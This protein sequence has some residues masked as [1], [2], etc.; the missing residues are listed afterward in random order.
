M[1]PAFLTPPPLP[2]RSTRAR[3]VSP[4]RPVM[5][6]GRSPWPFSRFVQTLLFYSP[7]GRFLHGPPTDPAERVRSARV[8]ATPGDSVVLV[9]GAN[10]GT[11]RR[12]V[13]D[14]LRKKGIVVRALVRT[15]AKLVE[16][17]A[18]VGVD[19]EQERKS[20]KL[21][22]VVS[23]LFNI[24]PEFFDNVVAVASCTGVNVGPADDP[25]RSKYFQ[26]VKFYPPSILDDTPENVEFVG[27]GNLVEA[28]KKYFKEG[29]G[30]IPVLTFSDD[31]IVRKQW[32]ALDD[33]VM[34]GVSKGSVRTQN[35][36]LVFSGFVSTDNSGG[37]SSARTTDFAQPLDVSQYDGFRLRVKGDGKSYKFIVR[38]EDKWDGIAHCFT[39]PT[40]SG[41]WMDVDIPFDQF[42][43]V[44]RA[45]TL[46]DGKPLDPKK[47]YAFQV[48]LSK[49][50]YD[51]ELN[52]NF[53]A[54]PF[55]LQIESVSAYKQSGDGV[56]RP[57]I[58]HIS[59]AAVTRVLRKSEFTP[60]QLPPAAQMNDQLG[61]I[62]NWKFAGED[63]IRNSGVPYTI[64]RPCALT[65]E[66]AV[67]MDSLLFE[68][69]DTLLG[70]VSRDDVA[71]LIIKAFD[72]PALVDV[73][74]EV[75]KTGEG[76][77]S[78]GPSEQRIDGLQQDQVE[79]RAYAQFP[80]VPAVLQET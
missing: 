38:C 21:Q 9:T 41:E 17:L 56:I 42:R 1:T 14:L 24:R 45:K 49:F 8:S 70:N 79:S 57:K 39:F 51:G 67:G 69:G 37:F 75:S 55:Q 4:R 73:T 62:L 5:S 16:A 60:E 63:A 46:P 18:K 54:G 58:V 32:G 22:V 27:I 23:D 40:K 30:Q 59:T 28:A 68:Q 25:D 48:M 77:A 15:E 12:V 29:A 76:A 31:E 43:A 20:G 66:E 65:E 72:T 6:S 33:V 78:P 50:E 7:L 74:V 52:P 44:F 2:V 64:L 35:G 13:R 34:G 19:A 61:R 10:G 36:C 11:G 71:T 3:A 47:V 53:S 26:G 80:Y